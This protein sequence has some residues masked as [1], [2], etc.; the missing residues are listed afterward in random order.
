MNV[1]DAQEHMF[2]GLSL[3]VQSESSPE[4]VYTNMLHIV[5]KKTKIKGQKKMS[6]RELEREI[7]LKIFKK[8][9]SKMSE[10]ENIASM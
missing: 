1:P 10:S 7:T 4:A 3:W 6:D 8:A 2:K 9:V 5:A